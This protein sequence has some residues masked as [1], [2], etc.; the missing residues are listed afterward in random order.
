MSVSLNDVTEYLELL[1]GKEPAWKTADE[2]A[3]GLR[4]SVADVGPALLEGIE[5]SELKKHGDGASAKYAL[6]VG[7]EVYTAQ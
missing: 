6:N 3:A 4:V 5:A 1:P 2:I 7:N